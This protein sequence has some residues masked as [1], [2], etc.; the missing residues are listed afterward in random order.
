MSLCPEL[1]TLGRYFAGEFT[2]RE[3]AIAEP[4]WYVNLRLWQ[5][6]TPLFADDSL[7]FFVEQANALSP[8]KPYRQRLVRLR[9]L[10]PTPAKLQVEYYMF[11]DLAAARCLGQDSER[12]ARLT[13]EEVEFLPGCTLALHIEGSPNAPLYRTASNPEQK[14]CFTY[15][16]KTYQVS[17]GFEATS[18]ELRV[19]DK[20]IDPTTGQ[21]TWG[22]L[23]GPFRFQKRQDFTG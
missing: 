4:A 9:Q 14:C 17:L 21:A 1:L 22:A 16:D 2:N 10:E 20:G 12:L 18:E 19:Y 13:S 5:R 3:Q 7:T 11:K 6:P 8:D 15:E 23:L